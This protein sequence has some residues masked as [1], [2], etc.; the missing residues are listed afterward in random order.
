MYFQTRFT[1]KKHTINN[2]H[3]LNVPCYRDLNQPFQLDLQT[4][5]IEHSN[6]EI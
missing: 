6:Q 5:I 4:P 2:K 3:T 1:F